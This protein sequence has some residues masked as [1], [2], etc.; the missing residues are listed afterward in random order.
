MPRYIDIEPVIAATKSMKFH[1]EAISIDGII[2]RLE[3]EPTADVVEV[4]HGEN[5][6]KLVHTSQFICSEC[7]VVVQDWGRGVYD[8][9]CFISVFFDMSFNFCPN[10]GVKIE[11]EGEST[12]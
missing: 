7:G 1:F 5:L 3:A 8:N 4:V 12:T 6:S 2:D 9:P 11:Q 10:C